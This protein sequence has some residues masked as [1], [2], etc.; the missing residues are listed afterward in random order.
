VNGKGRQSFQ[1]LVKAESAPK[2][3]PGA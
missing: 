2:E 1:A 3:E